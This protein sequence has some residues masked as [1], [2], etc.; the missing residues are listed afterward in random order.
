[1]NMIRIKSVLIGLAMIAAADLAMALTPTKHTVATAPKTDLNTMI[2]KQIG[3]WHQLQELD[4][5][6]VSPE[7]QAKLNEIYQ[8]TPPRSYVNAKGEQIMLPLAYEGQQ[9][10]SIQVHKPGI[11]YPEQGFEILQMHTGTMHI[12]QSLS[13][14]PVQSLVVKQ[15]ERIEPITYWIRA[16]DQVALGSL[17]CKLAQLKY[18]LTG[19]IPDGLLFRV[20]SISPDTIQGFMLQNEFANALFAVLTPA[21]RIKLPGNID[22]K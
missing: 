21:S 14:I 18:G 8:R 15:G 11:C 2:P 9:G 3:N 1:M 13:N 22:T 4:V 17:A 5:I 7:V 12:S 20:S 16:G 6:V 19:K 10:D